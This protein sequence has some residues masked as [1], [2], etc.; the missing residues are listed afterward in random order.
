M[1]AGILLRSEASLLI[2]AQEKQNDE[3][4]MKSYGVDKIPD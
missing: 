3:L 4:V 1:L 2:E